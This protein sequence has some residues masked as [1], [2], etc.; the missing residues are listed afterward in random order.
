MKEDKAS[1]KIIFIDRDGV[2]NKDPGGWTEYNYVTRWENF[3]FL[4]GSKE[5]MKKLNDRG[6]EIILVSNQAGVGKGHYSKNALNDINSK[7]LKEIEKSGGRIKKTYY[8]VHKPD[9]NCGCRKPETGLFR[10][11][12]KELGIK[13]KGNFFIGDGK[14]D[15]EAGRRIGLKTILV[16]SG[17]SSLKDVDTWDIKPDFIFDDLEK[18][19]D[20]ILKGEQN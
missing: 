14:M 2:I 9:D 10:Q 4:H 12:E 15:I 7:M 3:H 16:L 13:A 1:K 11:A 19:V 5:A 18:A 20:F 8:C 17:K 6:F